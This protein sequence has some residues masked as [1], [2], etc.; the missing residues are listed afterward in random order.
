MTIA[1]LLKH[2]GGSRLAVKP[3]SRV[4]RLLRGPEPQD[5]IDP[6]E[7]NRLARLVDQYTEEMNR[8]REAI[9]RD[10]DEIAKPRR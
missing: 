5:G 9:R 7:V 8:V 4:L 6:H 2:S 1:Q 10:A 3:V